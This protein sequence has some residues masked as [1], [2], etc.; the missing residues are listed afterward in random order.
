MARQLFLYIPAMLILPKF[1]G[2]TWVYKGSFVIDL[3]L[4]V[5]ILLIVMKELKEL[6]TKEAV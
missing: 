6:R 3:V 5:I 1:F 4:V 2:I